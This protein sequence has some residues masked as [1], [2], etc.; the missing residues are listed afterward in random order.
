MLVFLIQTGTRRGCGGMT[1]RR[2]PVPL[3]TRE[4]FMRF[5]IPLLGNLYTLDTGGVGRL[6]KVQFSSAYHATLDTNYE[7]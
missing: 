5:K 3:H 1:I 7:T 4:W 6:N 2:P